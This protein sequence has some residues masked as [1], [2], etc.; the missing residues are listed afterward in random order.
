MGQRA[1]RNA[2]VLQSQRSHPGSVWSRKSHL[3]CLKLQQHLAMFFWL[4]FSLSWR[5]ILPTLSPQ[6]LFLLLSEALLSLMA[7]PSLFN[8]TL[9]CTYLSFY[10]W[11]RA[12]VG[13]CMPSPPP[14]F[15]MYIYE[16]PSTF[17]PHLETE[18]PPV[19]MPEELLLG[20]NGSAEVS[21]H[22]TSNLKCIK[23]GSPV[24]EIDLSMPRWGTLRNQISI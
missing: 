1:V 19:L 23:P 24:R 18:I 2:N 3:Y 11:F 9:Q 4:L 17:L 15:L 12:L 21:Q 22:S 10:L 8:L 6:E 5:Y 16:L 13:F 14:L 7:F 20:K